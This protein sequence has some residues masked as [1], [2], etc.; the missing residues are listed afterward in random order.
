VSEEVSLGVRYL[1][2]TS[3]LTSDA[4]DVIGAVFL[5]HILDGDP[6]PVIGSIIT[7]RADIDTK[8]DL[9]VDLGLSDGLHDE[10]R[11]ITVRTIQPDALDSRR[12]ESVQT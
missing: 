1:S 12:K 9:H 7:I 10:M 5:E 11:K 8:V 4:R 2:F 6:L 3:K